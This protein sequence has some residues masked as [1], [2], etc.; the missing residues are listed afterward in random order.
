MNKYNCDKGIHEIDDKVNFNSI[1]N[2]LAKA[3]I[4]CVHCGY[5]VKVDHVLNEYDNYRRW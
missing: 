3:E 5:S 2:K 1:S 4:F